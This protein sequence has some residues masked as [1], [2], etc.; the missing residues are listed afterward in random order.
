MCSSRHAVTCRLTDPDRCSVR[1]EGDDQRELNPFRG[2]LGEGSGAFESQKCLDRKAFPPCTICTNKSVVGTGQVEDW[3][4]PPGV[5][6]PS[7]PQ[8]T[9]PGPL[10]SS[11]LL[12]LPLFLPFPLPPFPSTI[13]DLESLSL[14][15]S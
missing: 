11:E 2:Y 13:L 4:P 8:G 7:A 5:A 14:R 12:P 15:R 3:I 6:A 1:A 10:W 9:L